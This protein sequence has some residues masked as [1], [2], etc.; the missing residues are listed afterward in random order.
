MMPPCCSHE[1]KCA[2]VRASGKVFCVHTV[3]FSELRLTGRETQLNKKIKM[4]VRSFGSCRQ[5]LLA[6]RLD[7]GHKSMLSITVALTIC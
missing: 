2:C 1:Q 3:A 5:Q 4:P 7:F 6:N